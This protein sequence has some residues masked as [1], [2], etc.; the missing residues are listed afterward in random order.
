MQPVCVSVARLCILGTF[1]FMHR[2]AT[3]DTILVCWVELPTVSKTMVLS[4]IWNLKDTFLI[5]LI[6]SD[7]CDETVAAVIA[8][9]AVW[10]TLLVTQWEALS[11]LLAL[12]NEECC[13]CCVSTPAMGEFQKPCLTLPCPCQAQTNKKKGNVYIKK[14]NP[15]WQKLQDRMKICVFLNA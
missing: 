9:A 7:F 14:Y 13:Q 11:V 6:V 12:T 15:E 5:E 1:L 2:F 3:S 10:D 8:H 4:R